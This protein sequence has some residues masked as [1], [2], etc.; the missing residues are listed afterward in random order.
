M[1]QNNT[2]GLSHS[3]AI[4]RVLDISRDQG[5][6]E[7]HVESFKLTKDGHNLLSCKHGEPSSLY[8]TWNFF[9]FTIESRTSLRKGPTYMFHDACIY[10]IDVRRAFLQ[11]IKQVSFKPICISYVISEFNH[12]D[13]IIRIHWIC[14]CWSKVVQRLWPLARPN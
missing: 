12:C 8:F 14:D 11:Y 6:F 13:I 1:R 9:N 10:L 3:V 5:A 4:S 7:L 2:N